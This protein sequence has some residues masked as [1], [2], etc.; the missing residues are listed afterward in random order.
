MPESSYH[1]DEAS[2]SYWYGILQATAF[3]KGK[4]TCFSN[5]HGLLAVLIQSLGIGMYPGFQ[6]PNI[7]VHMD[8]F[9]CLYLK[10]SHITHPQTVAT[11][12][13]FGNQN[14]GSTGKYNV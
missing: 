13:Y 11:L 12:N 7:Q 10:I 2:C 4:N 1:N 3:Y 5:L 6:D 8:F 9:M 14:S